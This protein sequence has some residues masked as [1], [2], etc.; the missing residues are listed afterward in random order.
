MYILPNLYWYTSILNIW[1]DNNNNKICSD[2]VL[3][4][5]FFVSFSQAETLIWTWTGFWD[6]GISV[7]SC[8]TQW[9][10]P[11]GPWERD[12]FP[13]KKLRWERDGQAEVMDRWTMC[14]DIVHYMRTYTLWCIVGWFPFQLISKHVIV[15]LSAVW[16]WK[17]VWSLDSVSSE[18]SSSAVW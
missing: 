11:W 9:S 16:Q 17:C 8:G 10:L 2:K 15:C 13:A 6:T 4:C 7:T 18:R 12:L 5:A 1:V 3:L 14:Q